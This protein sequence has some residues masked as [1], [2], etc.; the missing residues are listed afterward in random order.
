MPRAFMGS[1]PGK[2]PELNWGEEVPLAPEIERGDALQHVLDRIAIEDC[3]Y[4]YCHAVD[5]CDAELLRTVYWP[6]G[7]DDHSF[8]SGNAMD[9]VDFCIP[10]LKSR[11][12]TLHA[13]GNVMMRL[14]GA[15]A[16][17]QSYY[18]AIE[19]VIGKGG[20]PNDVT[21]LGRYLDLFEKRGGD[22]KIK[23][24]KVVIDSWRIYEDSCDWERGV[25]GTRVD[26]GK[27]G[28]E[29]PAADLFGDRLFHRPF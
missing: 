11:G 24:R 17:V 26:T 29:D 20:A 18:N 16:R 28:D 21:F 19:R 3:L 22:W 14:E 25:F 13:I 4:R 5:R 2:L 15:E 8:W 6:D 27:R 12:Q 1:D 7:T 9:F 10:I 23:D